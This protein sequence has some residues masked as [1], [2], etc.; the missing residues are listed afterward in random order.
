M[1]SALNSFIL[2][3]LYF[4]QKWYETCW[5]G[6]LARKYILI[7]IVMEPLLCKY[8]HYSFPILETFC[9]CGHPL[10]TYSFSPPLRSLRGEGCVK[11]R[12]VLLAYSI[13]KSGLLQDQ[14]CM[15]GLIVFFSGLYACTYVCTY[16][17]NHISVC[18]YL[19]NGDSYSQK[20]DLLVF[21]Q[22]S[23][24]GLGLHCRFFLD[25]LGRKYC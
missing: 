25:S 16:N 7:H 8:L 12:T 1:K 14:L 13:S 4:K 18:S 17:D 22:R 10:Q 24:G 15:E 5:I 9:L 3:V 20:M 6:E 21:Q 19:L 2:R 23:S 11:A